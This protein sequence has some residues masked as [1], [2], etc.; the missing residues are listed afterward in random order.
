MHPEWNYS[1]YTCFI[2]RNFIYRGLFIAIG[3]TLVKICEYM[4]FSN[5]RSVKIYNS[6]NLWTRTPCKLIVVYKIILIVDWKASF[7]IR[8]D[9]IDKNVL[10]TSLLRNISFIFMRIFLF[11]CLSI[12]K[13]NRN[14]RTK[15]LWFSK[16]RCTQDWSSLSYLFSAMSD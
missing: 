11:S 14:L 7:A 4:Y 12:V 8:R 13:K 10:V 16:I 2:R 6:S 1:I 3:N 15:V 9:V 5:L